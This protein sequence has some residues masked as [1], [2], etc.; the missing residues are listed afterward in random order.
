MIPYLQIFLSKKLKMDQ[1]MENK[2]LIAKLEKEQFA[3]AVRKGLGRALMHVNNFGLDG[4]DDLVLDACLH[5]YCYDTQIESS[6][7]SWLFRMFDNTEYYPKFS[8]KI[9]DGLR[10]ETNQDNLGQ[11]CVLAKEMA[12]HGD[13]IA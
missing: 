9:L 2:H 10:T 12:K 11:L 6:R 5:N 7:A 4:I 3:S 13:K 8:E 1:S